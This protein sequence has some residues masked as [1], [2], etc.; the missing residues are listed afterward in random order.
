VDESE[1]TFRKARPHAASVEVEEERSLPKEVRVVKSGLLPVE[2]CERSGGDVAGA[3]EGE[4][5]REEG[6]ADLSE[7]S[8]E[9][10]QHEG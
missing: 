10:A 7:P 8:V 2:V 9:E 1:R 3:A 6:V 5:A 4:A